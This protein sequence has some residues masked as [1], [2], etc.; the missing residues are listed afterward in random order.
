MDIS[1]NNRNATVMNT[2]WAE[3]GAGGALFFN[4]EN[5]YVNC[6]RDDAFKMGT[7]HLSIELWLKTGSAANQRM[8]AKGGGTE[9]QMGYQVFIHN[10]QIA[11]VFGTGTRRVIAKTTRTFNDNRWHHVVVTFDRLRDVTVYVDGAKEAAEDIGGFWGMDIDSSD[12]LWIGAQPNGQF[13]AGYID[14]VKIYREVLSKV[15]IRDAYYDTKRLLMADGCLRQIAGYKKEHHNYLHEEELLY[16][17]KLTDKITGQREQDGLAAVK[18]TQE[19]EEIERELY[20]IERKI[21]LRRWDEVYEGTLPEFHV[22]E[23]RFMLGAESSLVKIG[24][25]KTDYVPSNQQNTEILAARHEYESFQLVFV[26]LGDEDLSVELVASDLEHETGGHGIAAE[27]IGLSWVEVL[28]TEAPV[29]TE[30][31]DP[32]IPLDGPISVAADKIQPFWVDIYVPKDALPGLYTGRILI[33][34]NGEVASGY[35]YTVKVWSF[36]LPVRP[37]LK[38]AFGLSPEF[39]EAWTPMQGKDIGELTGAYV[40][41]LLKHRIS[42]KAYARTSLEMSLEAKQE[43]VKQGGRIPPRNDEIIESNRAF[44]YPRYVL[45]K[46]G[47]IAIDFTEFDRMVDEYL[48]LGLSSFV[49]GNRYWDANAARGI[50]VGQAPETFTYR[51]WVYDEALGRERS[52]NLSVLSERHLKVMSSVFSQWEAHLKEKGW[53]DLAYIYNI[54]EPANALEVFEFVNKLNGTIKG[55]APDIPALITVSSSR[56]VIRALEH[57]DIWC[58][59]FHVVDQPTLAREKD[60]GKEIW[61]YVCLLP[62]PPYANF[63]LFQDAI[64]HRILFW[65]VFK[66]GGTGFLYWE[67]N[68]WTFDPWA[69]IKGKPFPLKLDGSLLYPGDGGPI[70]SIRLATIRDGI[71]DY[72]YLALLQHVVQKGKLQGS[73]LSRARSLIGVSAELVSTPNA[74]GKDPQL[75]LQYR[76]DLGD[77]L[78]ELAKRGLLD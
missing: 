6:G 11:G 65:Q 14:E 60:Q 13:F 66:Y 51:L 38:T 75:L 24:Q 44:F 19:L 9:T 48:S 12:P 10:G 31:P 55:A 2:M 46:D 54:D 72:D 78:D 26:P 41:H 70:S 34:I 40:R 1:G 63:F 33:R 4:G 68:Y 8:V 22:G 5:A 27:N 7:G 42:P 59:M 18:V 29:E 57:I 58:P 43:A 25:E 23:K 16:L 53:L 32:L 73:E 3:E 45:G 76:R 36:T 56:D 15:K 20:A 50:A 30:Y 21:G 52:L 69:G 39:I 62:E 77:F 17:T 71:E 49:A 28:K 37:A 64:D 61:Y 74:Y 67:T 47:Q 35:E